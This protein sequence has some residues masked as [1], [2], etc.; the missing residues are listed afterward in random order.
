MRMFALPGQRPT[1]SVVMP[2]LVLNDCKQNTASLHQS[3][4]YSHISNLGHEI[5]QP[6]RTTQVHCRKM[7]QSCNGS[8]CRRGQYPCFHLPHGRSAL[9][10]YLRLRCQ[11]FMAANLTHWPVSCNDIVA[12]IGAL[13]VCHVFCIRYAVHPCCCVYCTQHAPHSYCLVCCIRSWR[14]GRRS[15]QS[16]QAQLCTT[17]LNC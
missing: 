7:R 16:F 2:P 9:G 12:A 4:G 15:V 5:E 13:L 6:L 8:R 3:C 1:A 14:N 11:L 17:A 10:P